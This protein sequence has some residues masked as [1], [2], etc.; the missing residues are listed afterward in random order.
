MYKHKVKDFW[1]GPLVLTFSMSRS[2][3]SISMSCRRSSPCFTSILCVACD[4]RT[5]GSMLRHSS[6][7]GR[8][9]DGDRGW[10]KVVGHW[11]VEPQAQS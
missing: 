1:S 9:R 7:I 10:G 6:H 3:C 11:R 5:M 8:W 4:G 2:A